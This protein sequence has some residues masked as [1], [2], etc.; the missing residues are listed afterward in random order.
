[1]SILSNLFN[2]KSDSDDELRNEIDYDLKDA[3]A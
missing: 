1:M 2:N 3:N